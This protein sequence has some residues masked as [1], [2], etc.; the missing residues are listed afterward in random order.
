MCTARTWN[1][2]AK[3]RDIYQ[4]S[5]FCVEKQSPQ[6]YF[7]KFLLWNSCANHSICA[8]SFSCCKNSNWIPSTKEQMRW[9][10]MSIMLRMWM[11][12]QVHS[13][14]ILMSVLPVHQLELAS[15]VSSR[16]PSMEVWISLMG[17]C[18]LLTLMIIGIETMFINLLINGIKFY[19]ALPTDIA[20]R[21][22]SVA[23][24]IWNR[25]FAI[26]HRIV[27]GHDKGFSG[28]HRWTA[29]ILKLN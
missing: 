11:A 22:T 24:I 13:V 19:Q 8:L 25:A 9:M 18:C 16:V 5:H 4:M 10:V 20:T 17:E 6:D 29:K 15:L 2:V 26:S 28:Q 1:L 21:D 3:I 23:V 7:S 12:S 14:A 27:D